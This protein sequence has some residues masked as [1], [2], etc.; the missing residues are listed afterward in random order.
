MVVTACEEDHG[1]NENIKDNG[2]NKDN[3]VSVDDNKH[4]NV[5]EDADYDYAVS[6]LM[7]LRAINLFECRYLSN[8]YKG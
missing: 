2:D 8:K 7:Y 3:V 4:N 5:D 6:I 1:K